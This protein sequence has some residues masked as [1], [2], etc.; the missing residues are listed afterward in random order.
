MTV[1]VPSRGLTTTAVHQAVHSTHFGQVP[2]VTGLT[3]DL[4]LVEGGLESVSTGLAMELRR[5]YNNIL[6]VAYDLV[7]GLHAEDASQAADLRTLYGDTRETWPQDLP[8][9]PPE[10]PAGQQ[11]ADLPVGSATLALA[12]LVRQSLRPVAVV[13][14][15]AD[16]VLTR[17]MARDEGRHSIG[18]L[19]GAIA[20]RG[21]P[22]TGVQNPLL[23]IANDATAL[24]GGLT[25]HP[26]VQRVVIVPPTLE[27]R[28]VI[29]TRLGLSDE[30]AN[31]ASGIS[32]RRLLTLE[33]ISK[34]LVDATASRIVRVAVNG[35]PRRPWSAQ[36]RQ[37]IRDDVAPE[38]RRALPGQ[39]VVVDKV[40]AALAVAGLPRIRTIG[41]RDVFLLAGP[42]AVGKTELT[43]RLATAMFGDVGAIRRFDMTEYMESHSRAKLIG[44]PPGYVGFEG[45]GQLTD[46]VRANPDSIVL[47]DE[48]EKAHEDVLL[49]LLQILEDGRLTDGRGLTVD[50]TGIVLF[51]TTN[52]GSATAIEELTAGGANPDVEVLAKR[53]TELIRDTLRAPRRPDG[54]GGLGRPELWSRL[55]GAVMPFDVVRRANVERIVARLLADFTETSA[56]AGYCLVFDTDAV[57]G[58]IAG[59]PELAGAEGTWDTRTILKLLREHVESPVR[60]EL[61]RRGDDAV[62]SVAVDPDARKIVF[63]QG[64]A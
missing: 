54:S 13:I 43:R 51:M 17:A 56:D 23:L 31:L 28:L 60:H 32:R 33:P 3:D 30:V 12:G 50:F 52:M 61:S 39:E 16:L 9:Q 20:R 58:L 2:L 49:L 15:H 40:C 4:V 34:A 44:A 27:E 45:G 38:V 59:H 14:D 25:T 1:D 11:L 63:D 41:P 35:M 8:G 46:W 7:S 18:A 64:N 53:I 37:R 36:D 22:A 55:Q 5:I 29:L 24:D 62:L 42:P 6:V 26:L 48:L 21:T 57:S 10:I 19:R 47:L